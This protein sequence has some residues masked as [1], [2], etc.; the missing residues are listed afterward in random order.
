M[1]KISVEYCNENVTKD[2][3]T[4]LY[5]KMKVLCIEHYRYLHPQY[6]SESQTKLKDKQEVKDFIHDCF[7][8]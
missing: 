7:R 5:Y 2:Q 4:R 6:I 8:K 3:Q 1:E